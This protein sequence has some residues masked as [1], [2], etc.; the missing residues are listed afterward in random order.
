M[1]KKLF[2]PELSLI[3]GLLIVGAVGSVSAESYPAPEYRGPASRPDLSWM[4]PFDPPVT[5]VPPA[6]GTPQIA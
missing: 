4:A 1:K 6:D 2:E 3:L 5:N